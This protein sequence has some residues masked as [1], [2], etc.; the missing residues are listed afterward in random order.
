[1]AAVSDVA[2]VSLE[3]AMPP[4][5]GVTLAAEK[6]AVTPLGTPE[7]LKLVALLN[8]F[9]LVTVMVVETDPV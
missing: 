9:R 1:M 6:E 7:T 3:V 5:G 4:A 8:P 2:S